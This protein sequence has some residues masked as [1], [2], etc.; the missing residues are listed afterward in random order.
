VD[1][2]QPVADE[3]RWSFQQAER[4]KLRLCELERKQSAAC[5]PVIQGLREEYRRWVA[6]G[7]RETFRRIEAA[8]F[9]REHQRERA[10]GPEQ[11]RAM[12]RCFVVISGRGSYDPVFVEEAC[13][14]FRRPSFQ[15]PILHL[16][17]QPRE[18]IEVLSTAAEFGESAYRAHYN[19]RFKPVASG[20]LARNALA[21][22][23]GGGA[24]VEI[25]RGLLTRLRFDLRFSIAQKEGYHL[26]ER[27]QKLGYGFCLPEEG[28][29]QIRA[30]AQLQ[31]NVEVWSDLERCW[32]WLDDAVFDLRHVPIAAGGRETNLFHALQSRRIEKCVWYVKV[33]INERQEIAYTLC[34]RLHPRHGDPYT[35]EVPFHRLRRAQ[36]EPA[37]HPYRLRALAM[38]SERSREEEE[39]WFWQAERE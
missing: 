33:E 16:M 39:S 29:Y 7:Y 25:G 24:R 27:E 17:D 35:H 36:A 31:V 10:G 30:E 4:L 32:T 1:P 3:R 28:A 26:V 13:R 19:P 9:A 34:L 12:P 5:A 37:Q 2:W 38:R 23:A 11:A 21:G 15:A 6:T 20:L 8:I 22:V 14:F 18:R